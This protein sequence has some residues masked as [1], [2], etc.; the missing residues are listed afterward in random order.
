MAG[1][2]FGAGTPYRSYDQLVRA[3]GAAD[4]LA[5]VAAQGPGANSLPEGIA[6]LGAGILAALMGNRADKMERAGK[7]EYNSRFSNITKSLMGGP[8]AA[9]KK[10]SATVNA[11]PD[12]ASGIKATASH[13]G[14]DPVDLATAIS[15]ETAGT[16]DPTKK[17]PTTKWGT[18]RGLIQFGEPQAAKYGVDWNNPVGSQLGPEGAVARYLKDTGVQPGMGLLDIYSAINAGGVGR[19]NRS[20]AHAGGA[21]GTVADKVKNQMA[22]HRAKAEALLQMQNNMPTTATASAMPSPMPAPT[23]MASALPGP[24][25]AFGPQMAAGGP[26]VIP[27][28]APPPMAQPAP[29]ASSSPMTA[30]QRMGMRQLG[31]EVGLPTQQRAAREAAIMGRPMGGGMPSPGFAPSMA[32]A[33]MGGPVPSP[34]PAQGGFFT[35]MLPAGTPPEQAATIA[36]AEQGLDAMPIEQIAEMAN[37]PFAE[38]WQKDVMGQY[39]EHRMKQV[40]ADPRDNE[41]KRIQLELERR[42]LAPEPKARPATT[43]EKRRLNLPE[44]APV[45]IKPDGTPEL[46]DTS[47][48]GGYRPATPQEKQQFGVAPDAPL[49]MSPEGKPSILSDGKTTVNMGGGTDKQIFDETKARADAARAAKAGLSAINEAQQALPGAI[50]GAGANERLALRKVASLFGVG[51]TSAIADTET[52]RSAIAPQV[53]AMLKATVGSAQISNADREFAEKAAGGAIT[54]DAQSIQRLLNI[55]R[56]ANSEIVRGFNAD[57]NKVYPEGQGFDRERAL[58]GVPQANKSYSAPIGPSVPGGQSPQQ[59]ATQ[60]GG[61]DVDI[62]QLPENTPAEGED[63]RVYMKRNGKLWLQTQEGWEEVR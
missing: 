23:V 17:G 1:F 58:F 34:A 51:D 13:L 28:S 36:Q 19:Y 39:L 47:K 7:V 18:H 16:F 29:M 62:D 37:S 40:F 54:L 45:Y 3:R 26:Q 4:G 31:N 8:K 41:M 61:Y 49:M 21:P 44:N 57:L 52:F 50:T 22:E 32:P 6:S 15:Y 2:I 5:Q 48:L 27:A 33:P 20:D 42:K 35:S 10:A 12:I 43:D 25:P 56:T 60:Q 24:M 30:Y 38:D 9:P 63:G 55:M 11:S 46:I 59:P 53:A 14:I